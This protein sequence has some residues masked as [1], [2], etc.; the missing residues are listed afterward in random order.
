MADFFNTDWLARSGMFAPLRAAASKLPEIG[1][2]DPALLNAIADD[3]GRI[4]NARGQR[5]RFVAQDPGPQTFEAGF[6]AR[7]WLRG[8]VQVRPLDW[9]DLFNALVWMSFPAA[10]AVINARH[11]QSM[12]AGEGAN[13][14]PQR[15]ALT[16]FDEDG[17]VVLSDDPSLL[18]LVREFRWKAL[19]WQKRAEVRARM[20]FLL[21]G[22]ALYHKALDPFIGMTGKGLLIEVPSGYF[23][24]PPR[25]QVA[26]ADRR[27]AL[28][29]WD[30]APASG[31]DLSPVPVLGVPGWWADNE[32]AAFYD[33]GEYFRPGRRG[34]GQAGSPSM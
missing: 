33:N 5:L 26:E 32:S 6:E 9:H 21:F 31:R 3:C 13:R 8:E 15:D 2:P 19:F 17:V 12:S 34:K 1:W 29:F 16:L 14:P 10:K 22:H 25:A 20:R 7:A 23:D 18:A 4:V 30:A 11:C 28:Q 27:L 24:L